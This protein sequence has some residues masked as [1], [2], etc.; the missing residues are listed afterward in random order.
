MR[1]SAAVNSQRGSHKPPAVIK[2]AQFDGTVEQ[3]PCVVVDLFAAYCLAPEHGADKE[4]FAFPLDFSVRAHATYLE[5]L[6][7]FRLA[8]IP[9]VAAWRWQVVVDRRCLVQALM[10]TF[11]IVDRLKVIEGP[12]LSSAAASGWR[13]RILVKR[14]VKAF[15]ASILLRLPGRDALRRDAGLDELDRQR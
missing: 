6:G 13:R 12:L 15:M 4:E 5:V 7:I 9:V 2:D 11:G 10:R 14:Q 8:Q 1:P 3:A